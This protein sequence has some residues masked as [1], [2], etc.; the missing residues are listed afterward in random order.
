MSEA[1][2]PKLPSFRVVWTIRL[3]LGL[4][5][6][7]QLGR[8]P[9]LAA[10]GKDAPLLVNDLLIMLV[11]ASGALAALRNRRLH[12]D[13]VAGWALAFAAIGGISA[14]LAIPRFGLSGAEF[15]FS[16]AYLVRWLTYFAVYLV[17]IN[18]IRRDD[19]SAVLRT[20][21]G[22][23]LV[24]SVF[25]IFQSLFLPGFA[26][27][28]YPDS[29]NYT[30]WDP[31]GHRLV[32]TF[33]DPNFAGAFIAMVLLL[34]MARMAYGVEI[35]RWK[36]FVLFVALGLT[37]SRGAVIGFI[38]GTILILRVRG[39]SKG[40]LRFV[41]FGTVFML[42]A[43]PLLIQYAITYNKLTFDASAMTRVVGW[44]TGMEVFAQHPIIGV[45]FNTYG[46]VQ[47]KLFGNGVFRASF[48]LDGGLLFVAVLTGV[49]GVALYAGMIVSA[50]RR[51]RRIWRDATRSAEERAFGLGVGALSVGILVHSFFLNTLFYPFLMESLWVLWGLTLTLSRS[52][53]PA[54]PGAALA[55]APAVLVRSHSTHPTAP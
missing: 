48:G 33:L 6:V 50:M 9:V 10:G 8:I 24:F 18:F 16:I 32:S 36:L 1:G 4:M 40:L 39:L 47:A 46:F 28:V 49:V 3:A 35:A 53:R 55:E 22:A 21:E 43:L 34:Y 27:L 45:G 41:A 15:L 17:A 26:Q 30:D 13:S 52:D 25:G 20:F 2:T 42:V 29:V 11:V 54:E 23:V 19:F 38:A 14:V 31:Q 37:V 12:V 51:C 44:L 5:I 7:A